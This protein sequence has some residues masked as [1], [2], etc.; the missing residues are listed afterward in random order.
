[1]YGCLYRRGGVVGQRKRSSVCYEDAEVCNHNTSIWR[2]TQIW[3][4]LQ[5]HTQEEEEEVDLH[6]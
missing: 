3:R 4:Y 5:I 6:L 2:Y 1:M